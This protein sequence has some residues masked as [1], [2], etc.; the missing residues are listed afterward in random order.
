MQFIEQDQSVESRMS[1]SVYRKTLLRATAMSGTTNLRSTATATK[2]S[3]ASHNTVKSSLTSQRNVK[4]PA[5]VKSDISRQ[6]IEA[7]K[8]SS[9]QPVSIRSEPAVKSS[10]TLSQKPSVPASKSQ[11][12]SQGRV[13]NQRRSVTSQFKSAA[14][15]RRTIQLPAATARPQ[16]AAD[17]RKSYLEQLKTRQITTGGAD[18]PQNKAKAGCAQF[19]GKKKVAAAMSDVQSCRDRRKSYHAELLAR[20]KTNV[21]ASKK[22]AQ[23]QSNATAGNDKLLEVSSSKHPDGFRISTPS[24]HSRATTTTVTPSLSCIPRRKTVSFITPASHKS[25]PLLHRTQPVKKEMSM[26][27]YPDTCDIF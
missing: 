24:T 7:R 8:R 23:R 3:A 2:P 21:A 13:L 16:S 20:Q 1:C 11:S 26:R 10:E 6:N 5:G 4:Q 27:Y 15:R 19:N 22:P 14:D 25:T 9:Q 17:R 18:K 12:A